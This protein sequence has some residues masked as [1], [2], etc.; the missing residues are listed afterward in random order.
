MK[1]KI[2]IDQLRV[3]MY[4]HSIEGSWFANPFWRRRFLLTKEDDIQTLR[5][6]EIREVYIDCSKGASPASNREMPK[7][8]TRNPSAPVLSSARTRREEAT[9][10]IHRSKQVM[11]TVFDR[12]RLGQIVHASDVDSVVDEIAESMDSNQK[13]LTGLLRLKNKDEYTYAHSV[14]VC[15]LMIGLARHLGMDEAQVREVGMAGLLHDIGKLTIPEAI[16][17]K[18]DKL[19]D[20]EFRQIITHSERGADI[21]SQGEGIPAVAIEVCR[22]HHEKFDGTGY[23]N[24]LKGTDISLAARMAALC[25]VYDALTSERPYKAA[26]TPIEALTRMHQWEGHFDP[27]LFFAFCQSLGI[28]PAGMLCRTSSGMLG[29]IVPP[30]P[31]ETL[32]RL[33]LFYDLSRERI[34]TPRDVVIAGSNLDRP[35]AEVPPAAYDVRDWERFKNYLFERAER[36]DL[37][38]LQRYWRAPAPAV[39]VRKPAEAPITTGPAPTAWQPSSLN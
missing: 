5:D 20:Q 16:L 2:D 37:A 30:C 22:D 1:I 3:G 35:T 17:N 8:S 39:A 28:F 13:A 4:L 12:S 7:A 25:D 6:S 10:V 32:P 34:V 19:T 23:P 29:V 11:R 36:A 14:A 15:A 21:I 26:N 24:G 31:R 9:R 18:P 27:E 33:R 38:I